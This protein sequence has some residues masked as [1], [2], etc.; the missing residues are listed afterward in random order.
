MEANE[1]LVVMFKL[2]EE[3]GPK[4]TIMPRVSEIRQPLSEREKLQLKQR[5]DNLRRRQGIG[6][7]K[8]AEFFFSYRQAYPFT[9]KTYPAPGGRVEPGNEGW[10]GTDP[11]T[12]EKADW[13]KSEDSAIHVRKSERRKEGELSQNRRLRSSVRSKRL[14]SSDY[15]YDSSTKRGDSFSDDASEDSLQNVVQQEK[16]AGSSEKDLKLLMDALTQIPTPRRAAV[17]LESMLLKP[18]V[19]YAMEKFGTGAGLGLTRKELAALAI[20]QSA[21]AARKS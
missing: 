5:G 8:Y 14:R 6:S 19:Q 3:L 21:I 7:L 13:L 11:F 18:E 4:P 20:L 1:F 2:G 9:R 16:A 12:G 15:E 17:A 10:D